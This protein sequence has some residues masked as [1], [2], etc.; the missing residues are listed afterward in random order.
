MGTQG[1][2]VKKIREQ[3]AD[4]ALA[5]KG[6]QR[7]LLEDIQKTMDEKENITLLDYCRTSESAHGR[8]AVRECWITNNLS[9]VRDK[10]KWTDLKSIARI[11]HTRTMN[12]KTVTE[13]RHY[14]TSRANAS[15][16]L[17]T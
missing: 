8:E 4:Y 15:K 11:T 5:V 10:E 17:S 6:N 9:S 16:Y 1:W 14:I 12:G 7:R 3:S 2:I 13:T